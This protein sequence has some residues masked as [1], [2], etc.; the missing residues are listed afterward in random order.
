MERTENRQ[1]RLQHH[2]ADFLTFR[3]L[4]LSTKPIAS[5]LRRSMWG[6]LTRRSLTRR[7]SDGKRTRSRTYGRPSNDDDHAGDDR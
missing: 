1:C 4:L 2:K 6:V 3:G 7:Q 5:R